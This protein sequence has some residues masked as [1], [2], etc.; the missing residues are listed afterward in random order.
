[1]KYTDVEQQIIAKSE[2][3]IH[4]SA[5]TIKFSDE[6]KEKI[7]TE[8]KSAIE[9]KSLLRR[10]KIRVD[11]IQNEVFY[12]LYMKYVSDKKRISVVKF[13][14]NQIKCLSENPNIAKITPYKIKYEI[15]FK[16]RIAK[17]KDVND[18]KNEFELEGLK[19]DVF[20]LDKIN[21]LYYKWK[22]EFELYGVQ[23]FSRDTKIIEKL[24]NENYE[25]LSLAEK[26]IFLEFELQNKIEEIEYLKKYMPSLEKSNMNK[27]MISSKIIQECSS[28][29]KL[30]Y[31]KV[32][33][34]L[35][36]G[37]DFCD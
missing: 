32:L 33:R 6:I 10:E 34:D 17:I 11:L 12:R 25:N 35:N 14:H 7:K 36:L 28:D 21:K 13:S 20:T 26:K 30:S 3:V 23:A 24:K 27:D 16:I 22:R 18:V 8:C 19:G 2:H 5:T 29:V 1:M 9:I 31:V 37:M 4:I 15:H